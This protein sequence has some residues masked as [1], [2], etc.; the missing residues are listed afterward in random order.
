[1][2]YHPRNKTFLHHQVINLGASSIVRQCNSI[3][4]KN[5]INFQGEKTFSV[6]A[7]FSD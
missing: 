3:K 2:G 1:M 7:Q 6:Q 4:D 5:S